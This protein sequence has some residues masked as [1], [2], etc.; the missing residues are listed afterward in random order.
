MG[1]GALP[2]PYKRVSGLQV[3]DIDGKVIRGEDLSVQGSQ[4]SDRDGDEEQ[5]LEI[6]FG[7]VEDIELM[8]KKALPV[9][10]TGNIK[11]KSSMRKG[12]SIV[13][14]PKER[15]VFVRNSVNLRSPNIDGHLVRRDSASF[16]EVSKVS[17]GSDDSPR[18][19]IV[20]EPCDLE[21]QSFFPRGGSSLLAEEPES[22]KL[23]NLSGLVRKGSIL[24]N[25]RRQYE[26]I[27]EVNENIDH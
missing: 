23:L 18:V 3:K 2:K 20:A 1:L 12:E 25:P 9:Y 11:R 14:R 4:G 10:K 22:P 21:E 16:M 24:K 5:S 8:G 6:N 27:A 13:N 7:S 17:V 15:S 19:T 26:E